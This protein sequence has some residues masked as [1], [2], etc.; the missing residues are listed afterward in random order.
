[1]G[2]ICTGNGQRLVSHSNGFYF[3]EKISGLHVR[4]PLTI[5]RDPGSDGEGKESVNGSKRKNRRRNEDF[6]LPN[7]RNRRYFCF[8]AILAF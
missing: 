8:L 2:Y 5:L 6:P 7:V 3:R 4:K 1:M